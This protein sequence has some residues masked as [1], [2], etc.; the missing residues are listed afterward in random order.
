MASSTNI[1]EFSQV[2]PAYDSPESATE[3]SLPLTFFDIFWLKFPPVQRLFFYKLTD[4][5]ATPAFFN[6]VILPNL[7]NSL[8]L[9]L[10]HFLPLAGRLTWPPNSPKPIILYTPNDGVPLTIAE[11]DS[12]LDR[13]SSNEILDAIELHP[14]VPELPISETTASIL[15]LQITFFP[16]KGFCIG[17]SINHAVLDGTSITLFMKSWAYISKHGEKGK[18]NPSLLPEELVPF[19]DRSGFKDPLELGNLF[20]SQWESITESETMGNPRSLKLIAQLGGTVDKVRSTFQLTREEI[21]KLKN[22]VLSQLENPIHVST[23]VVTCAYVLVCM[24]KARGGDG[25]R[26]VW[27]L[28]TADSR[29]RLDPPLP[30]NYFGNCIASPDVVTEARYFMAENGFFNIAKRISGAI[31][32]LKKGLFQGEDDKLLSLKSNV[33]SEVQVIGLAGSTKFDVYGCDFGWGRPKKVEIISIDRTG[34]ISLT[35]SKDG[36][37]GVQIG[38]ALSGDEMEAF[39]S[40]FV[41]GLKHL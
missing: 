29:R 9:T 6:T 28:F 13:L 5:S 23:F 35:E 31:E 40:L 32:G 24:V 22:N 33:R 10:F 20:L 11:S 2:S 7:K 38:L 14:Y 1:L 41:D 4:P 12:D 36:N 30:A 8:A 16:N 26:M 18:Q 15:A 37:G 21:N 34:A 27:F 39:A 19:Y 3:F 25:N 17:Y